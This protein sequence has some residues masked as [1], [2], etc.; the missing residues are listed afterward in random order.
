MRGVS[1]RWILAAVGGFAVLCAIGLVLAAPAEAKERTISI[2]VRAGKPENPSYALARQ[3]AAALALG[4]KGAFA[5]DVKESQGSV[6]NVMDAPKSR[7]DTIFTTSPSLIRAARR[8]A[9]PFKKNPGYY[10]IRALFPIPFQTMQWIVRRDSRIESLK[11]LA[12]HSFVPGNK[13]SLSERLTA[14]ALQAL[15]IEK[16]VQLIDI[17]VAAAPAAIMRNAVSGLAVAGS[18]PVPMVDTI[19]KAIP[20]RLLGLDP[21]ALDKVLA[22][23]DNVVRQVIPKGTYP[24][25]DENVTTIAVPA[26]AYTTVRMSNTVA[27]AL[28]KAF[29][30]QRAALAKRDPAWKAVT[31]AALPALGIRLHPGALR[32]YEEADIA[33]PKALR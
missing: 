23:D 26:G 29:W 25:V 15:G 21:P 1:A 12:G 18:F 22:S 30:S 8:G 11:D 27:Y 17:D 6:Q 14:A 5:L 31:D 3:F 32:Y 13:F 7:A 9:K 4:G 10:D 24:G 20:I 19:A 28:T 16:K 2:V 33:I